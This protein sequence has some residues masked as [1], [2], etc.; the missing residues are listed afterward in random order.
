[1]SDSKANA[2]VS[3]I[4][5]KVQKMVSEAKRLEKIA[6]DFERLFEKEKANWKTMEKGASKDYVGQYVLKRALNGQDTLKEIYKIKNDFHKIELDVYNKRQFISGASGQM[7]SKL[8]NVL[9]GA[10]TYFRN[11]VRKF[12]NSFSMA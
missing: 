11:V 8:E 2:Y 12:E 6:L 10:E 3:S 4:I 5:T 9:D 7:A 1:M